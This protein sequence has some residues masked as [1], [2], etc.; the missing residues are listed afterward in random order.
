MTETNALAS[1]PERKFPPQTQ[2]SAAS[3]TRRKAVL[4][5][6]AAFLASHYRHALE[7]SV[8][9]EGS[10]AFISRQHGTVGSWLT[11]KPLPAAKRKPRAAT[12]RPRRCSF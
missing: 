7:I 2:T 12:L 8:L 5:D 10:L 11:A 6:T 1:A 9:G 4:L 3:A